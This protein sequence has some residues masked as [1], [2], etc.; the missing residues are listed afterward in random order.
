MY[1]KATRTRGLHYWR[2]TP[3]NSLPTHPRPQ[4][5]STAAQLAQ[6]YL[7]DKID[8]GRPFLYGDATWGTDRS[9]RRSITGIVAL[10]AGAA[11]LYKTKV[12]TTTA[13]SSTEAELDCEV[14]AGKAALYLRSMLDEIGITQD[15]PTHIFADNEGARAIAVAQ[16]PTRRTR[17]VELK[18]F[19]IMDWTEADLLTYDR[20]PTAVNLSDSLTKATGRIKHYEQFDIIMGYYPPAYIRDY[21]PHLHVNKISLCAW[22]HFTAL[23]VPSMGG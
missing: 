1:L 6:Y 10:F 19:A 4:P 2:R 23:M 22:N 13:L 21:L 9:H 8:P 16:R 5:V 14:N 3:N 11:I 7:H 15:L 18:N 20:C 17:H 12:Q